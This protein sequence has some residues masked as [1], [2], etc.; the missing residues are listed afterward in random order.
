M[1][2]SYLKLLIVVVMTMS[3]S[4][5]RAAGDKAV[6]LISADGSQRQE[7]LTNVDR[8]TLDASSLTLTTI[9]GK[10]E[11][12]A[13]NDID[14][15]LIGSEWTSVKQ[16]TVNGEIAV[17]PTSTTDIV[18]VGGIEP[19]ERVMI[20]DTKGATVVNAQASDEIIS[21]SLSHLPS[22]LYILTV[23][24]KSVKIIKK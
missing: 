5:I 3:V 7:I 6:V 22:G 1:K 24:D 23:K 11:T 20:T 2:Q 21:V 18:N 16:L 13:Y 12:V 19:G 10:S 8:I 15:I 17:W 4:V 14:R 9:D